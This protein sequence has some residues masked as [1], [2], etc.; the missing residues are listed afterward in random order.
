MSSPKVAIVIYSLYGHIAQLAEAE[1]KGIEEA[2]GKASIFQIRETLP[3]DVLEKMHAP[4]KPNYPIFEVTQLTDYDAFLFGIPTRYGNFPAQWKAFWDA[5]GKLWGTG[6]L[7]GKYVGVFVSTGSLGGG[8]ETTII[9]SLSTFVHHGMI[10]VPLGYKHT[11]ASFM[12]L[13][14]VH[15]G[16][17]FGAGTFAGGDGSRQPS[18]LELSVATTQG[19]TFYESV[20]RTKF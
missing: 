19:K 18:A 4:P 1:K 2:G 11:F 17:P 16:G 7:H 14:E 20:S 10:F 13:N 6:E 8:Q 3:Q 5:T 12:N 9:T 15:G